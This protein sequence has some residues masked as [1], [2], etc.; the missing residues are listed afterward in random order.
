MTTFTPKRFAA[1]ITASLAAVTLIGCGTASAGNDSYDMGHD[2]GQGLALQ[3]WNVGSSQTAACRTAYTADLVDQ[4][5][6]DRVFE[7]SWEDYLQGCL[8]ALEAS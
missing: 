1:L 4:E 7:V 6:E 8:S 2:A 3:L 5:M